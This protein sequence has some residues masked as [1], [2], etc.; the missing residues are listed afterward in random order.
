[1]FGQVVRFLDRKTEE[2][3]S[4]IAE[5]LV[6]EAWPSLGHAAE[7]GRRAQREGG[8]VGGREGGRA[9]FDELFPLYRYLVVG[10]RRV[11][12]PLLGEL[13]RG[14]VDLFFERLDEGALETVG[15]VVEMFPGM[16][17]RREGGK[18]G[19]GGSKGSS[20]DCVFPDLFMTMANRTFN[21][22][23][24][25]H[26]PQEIPEL[27]RAFF[28]MSLRL[29]PFR[30]HVF[31]MSPALPTVI[32]LA[33][34]CLEVTMEEK[35]VTRGVSRLLKDLFKIMQEHPGEGYVLP[36]YLP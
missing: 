32:D 20:D 1:M 30:R 29:L 26:P 24:A 23:R 5:D 25:G 14:N 9:I 17:R 21:Y 36:T 2:E 13:L 28:D 6:R 33:S 10:L 35:E 4:F 15:H 8:G 19:V 18:S 16:D 7:V 22:T 3:T 12:E 34:A 31:L 11:F 27:V